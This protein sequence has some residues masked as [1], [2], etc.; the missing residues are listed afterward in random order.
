LRELMKRH[1]IIGDV[2]GKGLMIGVELVKDRATKEPHPDALL[3]LEVECF[4]RG[5]VIQG[6]GTSTIRLSPPLVIDQEQCDFA[7]KTLD[8]ALGMAKE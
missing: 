6:A 4:R 5:L 3:Q 8:E 7:L 2:R 1:E